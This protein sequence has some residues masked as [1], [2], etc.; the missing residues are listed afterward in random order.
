MESNIKK[1]SNFYPFLHDE[2]EELKI[3][4]G[5]MNQKI[6][7]KKMI[8]SKEIGNRLRVINRLFK[9]KFGENFFQIKPESLKFFESG[10]KKYLFS[11]QSEFLNNFPKLKSKINKQRKIKEEKLKEKINMGS[12]LY[13]SLSSKYTK[14]TKHTN[15]NDKL[16]QLS[17]NLTTSMSKDMLSNA[18]YK[19]KYKDKNKE[20]FNKILSYRNKRYKL[21]LQH[22]EKNNKN[23]NNENNQFP[24]IILN[25]DINEDSKNNFKAERYLKTYISRNS[26]LNLKKYET[27]TSHLDNLDNSIKSFSPFSTFCNNNYKSTSNFLKK[28]KI[29]QK[30]FNENVENLNENTK[31]CN[32]KL[33]RLIN[34]N[35]KKNMRIKEENNKEM[36][37][38]KA[39]LIG[40]KDK[41]PKKKINNIIQIKSLIKKAKLDS[42]GEATINKIRKNE[43]KNFGHYIHIMSDNLALDKVNVLFTKEELK[44]QG[45]NFSRD[46]FERLRKKRKKELIVFNS[47]KKTKDNYYKILRLENDL[48]SIKDKFE[49][50][51]NKAILNSMKDKQL[52]SY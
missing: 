31:I 18:L 25:S 13:L 1:D 28:S 50:T 33:I 14:S 22:Q 39:I 42:E 11:P 47:R 46:E 20:R 9:E 5:V 52:M 10:L 23:F 8:I 36:I 21:Q 2:K 24:E 19:I 51:N 35:R 49:K 17:K 4:Q 15:M 27:A 37:N 44:L 40:K 12:L 16:F 26:A 48:T 38:L 41:K 32:K 34:G 43:L 3:Y 6:G 7:K 29:F 30:D 45:K